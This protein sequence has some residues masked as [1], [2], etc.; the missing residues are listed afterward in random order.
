M[1][2]ETNIRKKNDKELRKAFKK[3]LKEQ[4]KKRKKR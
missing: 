2:K 1:A 3:F 4:E